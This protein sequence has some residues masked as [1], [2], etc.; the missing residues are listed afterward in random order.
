ME[1]FHY[2]DSQQLI[3]DTHKQTN[4]GQTQ[5]ELFD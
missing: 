4:D 3:N 5:R 2:N 1:I